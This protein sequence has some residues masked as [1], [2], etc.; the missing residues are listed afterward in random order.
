[1]PHL[2]RADHIAP[3]DEIASVQ[4]AGDRLK[5]RQD[6]A[7]VRERQH[8]SVD[9]NTRKVHDAVGRRIDERRRGFDVDA[10]VT[11]AVGRGGGEVGASDDARRVDG[12]L[13]VG[14][15]RGDRGASDE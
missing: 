2:D 12:P 15:G 10:A 13:P 6:A 3:P 11:G 1:M 14:R 7:R 8:F 9:H 5:R 4:R